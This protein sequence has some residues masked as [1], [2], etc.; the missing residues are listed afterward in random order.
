M[1]AANFHA[2]KIYFPLISVPPSFPFAWWKIIWAERK[3]KGVRGVAVSLLKFI[4]TP[5]AT[6]ARLLLSF[7]MES[8]KH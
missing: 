7:L 6:A 5:Q 8:L 4:Q 1:R 2:K 3:T